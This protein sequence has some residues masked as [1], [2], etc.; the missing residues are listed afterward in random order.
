MGIHTSKEAVKLHEHLQVNVLALRSLAVAA[1]H[2]VPVQ[3][4]T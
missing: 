2:M 3:V 1:A 4:D